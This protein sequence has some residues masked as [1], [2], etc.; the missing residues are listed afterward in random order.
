MTPPPD[1][2]EADTLRRIGELIRTAIATRAMR[3]A[4]AAAEARGMA[5]GIQPRASRSAVV[6][7]VNGILRELSAYQPPLDPPEVLSNEPLLPATA[8]EL[9]DT[10]AFAIRFNASGK[11]RRTGWESA[12]QMAAG[13]LVA[14]LE[15]S[16]F[17]LMRRR[18]S[19]P[20]APGSRAGDDRPGADLDRRA[21]RH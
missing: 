20:P 9:A 16:G 1:Q 11:A 8:E 4:E 21:S 5:H 6:E 17:V 7:A 13:E 19:I 14:R 15:A 10:L 2:L 3:V 18:P 12:A